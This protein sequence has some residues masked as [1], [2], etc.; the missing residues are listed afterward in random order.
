MGWDE[1]RQFLEKAAGA[2][3]EAGE[4]LEQAGEGKMAFGRERRAE[5]F[6]CVTASNRHP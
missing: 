5:T 4:K 3:R 2:V 1:P 6:P